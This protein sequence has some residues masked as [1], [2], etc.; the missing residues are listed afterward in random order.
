[1]SR[2]V[3]SAVRPVPTRVATAPG[4]VAAHAGGPH[5]D[6]LRLVLSDQVAAGL[7]IRLGAVVAIQR[8]IQQIGLAGAVAKGLVTEGFYLVSDH[9]GAQFNAQLVGQ[10]TPLA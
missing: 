10:F 2:P 7:K 3:Q 4:Q 8:V 6:H 1:M 5:Q 9:Q